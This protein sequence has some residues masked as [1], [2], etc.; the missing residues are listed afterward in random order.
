[1]AHNGWQMGIRRGALGLTASTA[2]AAPTWP[3]YTGFLAAAH[4]LAQA[5]TLR[6][7]AVKG[8]EGEAARLQAAATE[9]LRSTGPVF[10]HKRDALLFRD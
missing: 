6:G 2:P 1:M 9:A 8:A 5:A 10:A 4:G 7:E 3:Q